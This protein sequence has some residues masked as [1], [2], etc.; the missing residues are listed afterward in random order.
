MGYPPKI[1]ADGCITYVSNEVILFKPWKCSLRCVL[2]FFKFVIAVSI[3]LPF[4]VFSYFVRKVTLLLCQSS[5][6]ICFSCFWYISI[7]VGT[8]KSCPPFLFLGY[9]LWKEASLLQLVRFRSLFFASPTFEASL[10][11]QGQFAA[12]FCCSNFE[13]GSS[14]LG[15]G[16]IRRSF[17]SPIFE[18][19]VLCCNGHSDRAVVFGL[20]PVLKGNSS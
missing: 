10:C 9:L 8:V 18:R 2:H 19:Q 11:C 17:F 5:A 16:P 20:G 14:L 15:Q 4:F 12:L 1:W 7:G 6:I 13:K 3:L